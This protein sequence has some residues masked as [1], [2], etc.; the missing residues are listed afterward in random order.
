ML[1]FYPLQSHV[2]VLVK[3]QKKSFSVRK[4]VNVGIGRKSIITSDIL[5]FASRKIISRPVTWKSFVRLIRNQVCVPNL[6][7]ISVPRVINTPEENPPRQIR[8]TL[9]KWRFSDLTL[10][11][12]W[13]SF[14]LVALLMLRQTNTKTT[15]KWS[16]YLAR[17][18]DIEKYAILQR[19]KI[20][21]ARIVIKNVILKI[22]IRLHEIQVYLYWTNKCKYFESNIT[23]IDGRVTATTN[24]NRKM[25]KNKM[26]VL[27]AIFFL[28]LAF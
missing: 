26:T 10:K 11:S 12:I 15:F 25:L 21:Q 4:T 9:W 14:L 6:M 20:I 1:R 19:M 3:P 16:N 5:S 24:I 8:P 17:Y 28:N 13:L 27:L 23:K 18:G 7:Y 22:Q 2:K